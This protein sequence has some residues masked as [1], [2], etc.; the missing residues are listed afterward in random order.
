MLVKPMSLTMYP[1]I[2]LLAF[3]TVSNGARVELLEM[4]YSGKQ[5]HILLMCNKQL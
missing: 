4:V 1:E 3:D 2:D 5:W